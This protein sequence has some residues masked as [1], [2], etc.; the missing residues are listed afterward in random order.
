L[1]R[2]QNFGDDFCRWVGE[3]RLQR[4]AEVRDLA[5]ILAYPEAREKFE[6]SK[7]ELAVET[8]KRVLADALQDFMRL[9]D[10]EIPHEKSKLAAE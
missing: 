5:E 7:R 8:A 4:G 3:R 2:D 6:K 9:A 1:E 10:V